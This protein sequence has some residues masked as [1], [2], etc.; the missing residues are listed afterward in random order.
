MSGPDRRPLCVSV[1][2]AA[3]APLFLAACSTTITS[4]R[5]T[6]ADAETQ[7][8]IYYM[9][10]KT[11]LLI[12]V[13]VVVEQQTEAVYEA[14]RRCLQACEAS[15]S[16]W[17]K[18]CRISPSTPT[19]SIKS[20]VVTAQAVPDESQMF[21]LTLPEN[22]FRG[23]SHKVTLTE[24]GTLTSADASTTDTLADVAVGTVKL[25]ASAAV[26]ARVLLSD[27]APA[28]RKDTNGKPQKSTANGA[29]A[30]E[31]MTQI[32]DMKHFSDISKLN[33]QIETFENIIAYAQQ[34][35]ADDYQARVADA[36]AALQQFLERFD[37]NG[38]SRKTTYRM[39]AE[40]VDPCT[41]QSGTCAVKLSP[42]RP[43]DAD[44]ASAW[45]KDRD[46][47]E[48]FAVD[49]EID[50][51]AGRKGTTPFRICATPS[52][53]TS[54][55]TAAPMGYAYRIPRLFRITVAC[56]KSPNGHGCSSAKDGERWRI[57]DVQLPVAQ[58]G[59]LAFLPAKY[60]G[61]GAEVGV[62]LSPT[63]GALLGA[64]I[65]QTALAADVVTGPAGALVDTSK[66]RRADRESAALKRLEAERDLLKLRKEIR[67]LEAELGK[68]KSPP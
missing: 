44:T 52:T 47:L 27:P 20:A 38:S 62:T 11:E 43:F 63:T 64:K 31:C 49:L 26:P 4:Q 61:K 17:K 21:R 58:F 30:Q 51:P 23:A 41:C 45:I 55:S 13:P 36:R 18:R 56:M 24:S 28:I 34:Q 2:L 57:A 12:S 54:G 9:L 48:D 67:D 14:Y 42:E 60:Y 25:A 39:I 50:W 53:S 22:Y 3:A 19:V 65:G 16:D 8:G 7:P 29:V 68:S 10:P 5:V 15:L 66:A 1:L 32:A 33:S 46:V 59:T 40:P 35:A 37:L 6:R